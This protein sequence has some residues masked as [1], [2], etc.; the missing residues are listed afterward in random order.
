VKGISKAEHF[1]SKKV[2]LAINRFKMIEEGDRVLVG[3]SG[4]KDSLT[5]LRVLQERKKWVPIDYTV[6]AVHVTTDYEIKP[7]VRKDLLKKY[8]EELG[9]DYVFKDIKIA[10]K[11]KLGKQDCFWCSWNRRRALFETAAEEGFTKVAL[12]HHKDDIAETVLMNMVYNGEL[13]GMNPVQELFSGKIIIIRPL[14]LL[15]EK[16]TSRYAEKT[17]L[18]VIRSKCPRNADSKRAAVKTMIGELARNNPEIKDNILRSLNRIKEEY[19][20]DILEES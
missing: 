10:E 17:G 18:P 16:D 2:G 6:K 7:K 14:V 4:G 3:V 8:F 11:N 15:E 5:L 9:C 12:G 20:T 19:V 1:I 13:S